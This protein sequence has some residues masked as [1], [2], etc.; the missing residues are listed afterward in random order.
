MHDFPRTALRNAGEGDSMRLGSYSRF[1]DR[2]VT[3]EQQ[4]KLTLNARRNFLPVD[5][6]RRRL[7]RADRSN[8]GAGEAGRLT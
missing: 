2:H 4:V 7:R 1:L 8:L 6:N 3:E 5:E